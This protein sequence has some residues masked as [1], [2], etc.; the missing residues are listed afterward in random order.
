MTL[1]MWN[2]G[3]AKDAILKFVQAVTDRAMV[4]GRSLP[5]RV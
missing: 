1:P 2:D 4:L 5:E 3:A